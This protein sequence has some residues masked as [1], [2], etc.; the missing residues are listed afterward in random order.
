MLRATKV[1]K[2]FGMGC[3]AWSIC[4]QAVPAF[5]H[6]CSKS[7]T[8]ARSSVAPQGS[9]AYQRAGELTPSHVRRTACE[10]LVGDFL[11]PFRKLAVWTKVR[12]A[13]NHIPFPALHAHPAAQEVARA[14]A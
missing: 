14:A 6:T 8:C 3:G 1:E 13:A 10:V 5:T 9:M 2:G 4:M 12:C 11:N 7:V